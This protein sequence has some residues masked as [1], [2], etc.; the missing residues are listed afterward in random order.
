MKHR[1][2]VTY[3]EYSRDGRFVATASRDNTA[4]VWT[5]EPEMPSTPPLQLNASVISARFSSDGRRLLTAGG[6]IPPRTRGEARVW[7]AATGEPLT[8]RMM[9]S[10]TVTSASF[11]PDARVVVTTSYD[12][13]VKLWNIAPDPRTADGMTPALQD[14]VFRR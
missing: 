5:L 6:E 8:T 3:V 7:D 13:T 10:G 12:G 2:S 1:R 11:S 9:H 14:P 4:R